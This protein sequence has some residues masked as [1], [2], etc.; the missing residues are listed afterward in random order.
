ML[1]IAVGHA[2]WPIP[3]S[4]WG[5]PPTVRSRLGGPQTCTEEAG[6][7]I[8]W[9]RWCLSKAQECGHVACEKHQ[10][11]EHHTLGGVRSVQLEFHGRERS[12]GRTMESSGLLS[13]IPGFSLVLRALVES[14]PFCFDLL[15]GI[16]EDVRGAFLS[17]NKMLIEEI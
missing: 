10:G 7:A 6:M 12:L 14:K 9:T 3:G 17:L 5:P 8:S 11:L 4:L 1:P 2:V 15:R 13:V 16:D